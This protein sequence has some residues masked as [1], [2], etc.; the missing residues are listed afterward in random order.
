MRDFRTVLTDNRVIV[1]G[2]LGLG[3]EF[4]DQ[5]IRFTNLYIHDTL[6]Q[7]RLAK[8][9]TS[10]IGVLPGGIQPF[11]EQNTNWFERQLIDSQLVGEF[12]FGDF[13]LD[14]RGSY[15]KTERNS[16]YER[17]FTYQY[18]TAVARLYVNNLSRPAGRERQLLRTER[19]PVVG[20]G[21]RR[22]QA[23]D[24]AADHACRRGYYYAD[25]DRTST[26]YTFR[27]QLP[28]GVALNPVAAQQR[29]DFLLS[30][31]VDPALRHRPAEHLDRA[32]APPPTTPS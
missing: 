5:K 28:G 11:I 12:K 19:E 8:G 6:K 14:L 31:F 27:Y 17:A 25:T 7:A 32:R 2:L 20:P 23:A 22:L 15:A 10:N 26:R 30:R 9:S 29:P 1:N 4:G 3:A 16:P 24:R 13:E 21:G 18:N